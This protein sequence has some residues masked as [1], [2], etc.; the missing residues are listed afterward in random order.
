MKERGVKLHALL[1][2]PLL[3]GLSGSGGAGEEE[4]EEASAGA[5]CI[6]RGDDLS[7]KHPSVIT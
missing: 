4:A 5:N 3:I 7:R 2:D 1:I 6:P